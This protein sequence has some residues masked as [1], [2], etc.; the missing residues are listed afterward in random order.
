MS[1]GDTPVRDTSSATTVAPRVTAETSASEPLNAVP[2]A[3]RQPATTTALVT[4]N[5]SPS[6]AAE[7]RIRWPVA[8]RTGR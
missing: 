4:G 6:G 7:P 5:P 3:V 2:I 1:A 8:L